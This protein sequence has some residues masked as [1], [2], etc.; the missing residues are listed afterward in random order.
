ME[1]ER[2]RM[3]NTG[4]GK[5]ELCREKEGVCEWNRAPSKEGSASQ[6]Y[7]KLS[8]INMSHPVSIY[9]HIWKVEQIVSLAGAS[10]K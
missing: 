2:E 6:P 7:F 4:R 9:M 8:S 5:R 1:R 3:R 10:H